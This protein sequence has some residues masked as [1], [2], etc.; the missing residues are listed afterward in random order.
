VVER[1]PSIDT[2]AV[3]F[4]VWMVGGVLGPSLGTIML[5]AFGW[6]WGMLVGV[7][8]MRA[9]ETYRRIKTGWFVAVSFG[10]TVGGAGMLANWVA[11]KLQTHPF[12]L[13]FFVA[14]GIPA[15]GM[16][17]ID[18]AK[19]AWGLRRRAVEEKVRGPE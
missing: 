12:E 8:L 2:I 3:A 6:F 5:I 4:A 1:I 9:D 14:V 13:L 11:P 15:V 16:K 19:W 17:W 18:L 10:V 7:W